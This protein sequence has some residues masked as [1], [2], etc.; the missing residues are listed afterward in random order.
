MTVMSEQP[1][2]PRKPWV[3]SNQYG[4]K[5]VL[6]QDN[7]IILRPSVCEKIPDWMLKHIVE[8]A[9]AA[10]VPVPVADPLA[11]PVDAVRAPA[12]PCITHH[13]ACGCREA[14]LRVMLQEVI[15]WHSDP[16]ANLYNGC[17]EQPCIWCENAKLLLADVGSGEQVVREIAGPT[18]R[19]E[20]ERWI[21]A[22]PYE[23]DVGRWPDDAVKHAWPGHYIDIAVELAW[24]AWQRAHGKHGEG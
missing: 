8:A 18:V 14:A 9:N 2:I 20:F 15:W 3:L 22:P 6:S 11:R 19:E 12:R 10:V 7:E 16:T 5:F 4:M 17:D 13:L 24:E 1:K 21:A 23:R